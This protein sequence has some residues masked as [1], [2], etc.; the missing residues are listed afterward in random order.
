MSVEKD[1]LPSPPPPYPYPYPSATSVQ[2]LLITVD[3]S[4][5]NDYLP[6]SIVNLL[7]G[8]GFFGII[9]LV[10]S[11]ICRN[12]KSVNNLSGAQT[13]SKLALVF[14]ILITIGGIIGWAIF[15][16]LIPHYISTLHPF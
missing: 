3:T 10:F 4:Y 16:I 14:N 9:P 1:S 12:D 5:I 8:W 7:C 13:M 15:I 2:P 6:W 11:I